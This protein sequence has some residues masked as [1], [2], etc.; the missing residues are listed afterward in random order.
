MRRSVFRLIVSVLKR[1][2]ELLDTALISQYVIYDATKSDLTGSARDYIEALARL[3]STH[4]QI[5]TT[6]YS[7]SVKKSAA[8]ALCHLLRKGASGASCD[9]WSTLSALLDDVPDSI[10]LGTKKSEST[11]TS[12][13]VIPGTEVLKEMAIGISR[14]EDQRQDNKPAWETYL[15]L[16]ARV[17]SLSDL[18]RTEEFC[19]LYIFPLVSQYLMPLAETSQWSISR[20]RGQL[21]THAIIVA[22]K[23]SP[24]AVEAFLKQASRGLIEKLQISLPEKS[25]DYVKSQDTIIEEIKRWYFVLR[26]VTATPEQRFAKCIVDCKRSERQVAMDI[27]KTRNGKPYSAAALLDLQHQTQDLDKDESETEALVKFAHA[28]VPAL[29]TTPSAPYLLQLLDSINQVRDISG[30][31]TECLKILDDAPEGS[32]KAR[33]LEAL[34]GAQWPIYE[35]ARNSLRLMIERNLEANLSGQVT[36]AWSPVRLSLRNKSTPAELID[37]IISTLVDSLSNQEQAAAGLVGLNIAVQ[38]NT[39]SLQ[40]YLLS[41]KGAGLISKLLYFSQSPDGVAIKEQARELK[42]TTDRLLSQQNNS[43]EAA[44][45]VIEIVR[46]NV[47]ETGPMSIS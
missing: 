46:S 22:A 6:Q 17:I 19:N 7:G 20:D 41:D 28:N 23:G 47:V 36:E 2:P 5:W 18:T 9:Y 15:R 31:Y 39:S 29:I 33:A 44:V 32:G 30:I 24:G 37:H 27:L 35:K 3:T 16:V 21:C 43:S 45:S 1:A 13:E 11:E 4:P 10:I 40:A 14:K 34:L 42:V 25:K 26:A 12:E 38:E 8:R